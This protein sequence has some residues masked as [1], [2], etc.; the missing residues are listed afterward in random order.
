MTNGLLL[1]IFGNKNLQ[2][3]ILI[4]LKETAKIWY[5]ILSEKIKETI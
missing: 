4:Y 5:K 2:K 1:S 3:Y